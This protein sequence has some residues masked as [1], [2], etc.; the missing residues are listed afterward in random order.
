MR[1]TKWI[2][3][4]L[5]VACM[6][7]RHAAAQQGH[8]VKEVVYSVRISASQQMFKLG[9]EIDIDITLT[10]KTGQTASI[11]WPGDNQ[12]PDD[13]EYEITVLDQSG[14]MPNRTR[15]GRN[16]IDHDPGIRVGN[17]PVLPNRDV[18]DGE[19]LKQ[20]LDLT[21]FFVFQPG[22]YT[23]E[24]KRREGE[25]SQKSNKVTITVTT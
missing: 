14:N 7:P 25:K 23:V 9:S 5:A 11:Y 22:E 3:L 4:I 20:K 12:A 15:L 19:T 16:V 24:L 10:N 6:N 8:V 1:L 21:K 17:G 18:K 2:L 13:W